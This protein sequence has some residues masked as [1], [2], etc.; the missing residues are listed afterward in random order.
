MRN[1]HDFLKALCLS[2]TLVI[3]NYCVILR[4]KAALPMCDRKC[5]VPLC[6]KNRSPVQMTAAA[7]RVK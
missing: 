1:V 4:T 6:A 3:F 7:K 5:F 2:A